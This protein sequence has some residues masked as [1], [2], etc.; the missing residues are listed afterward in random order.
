[1][2]DISSSID[3]LELSNRARN[4][5]FKA[6]VKTIGELIRLEWQ[7]VRRLPGVGNTVVR[8]IKAELDRLGLQMMYSRL[9]PPGGKY[10]GMPPRP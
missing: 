5:L 2:P 6:G 1:M 9:N 3:E 4:A 10:G 8:E 7:G